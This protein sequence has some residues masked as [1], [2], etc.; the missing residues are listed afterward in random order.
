MSTSF[1]H[2][3][4]SFSAPGYQPGAEGYIFMDSVPRCGLEPYTVTICLSTT[5]IN[6]TKPIAIEIKPVQYNDT[7]LGPY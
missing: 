6:F 7:G 5:L 4:K 2:A 3:P 1:S